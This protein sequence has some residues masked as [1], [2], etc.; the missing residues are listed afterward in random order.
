[1]RRSYQARQLTKYAEDDGQHLSAHHAWS[2]DA[3][4]IVYVRGDA[5]NRAGENPNPTSDPA[6]RGTERC[7]ASLS[8]DGGEP[9]QKSAWAARLRFHRA[10]RSALVSLRRGQNLLR[11]SLG[12]CEGAEAVGDPAAAARRPLRW[13]PDGAKLAF[14]SNRGDHA[15]IGVYEIA[16]KDL[17]WLGASV[18]QDG[19]PSWSPDGSRIAF[20]ALPSGQRPALFAPERS[21]IP[22]SVWV[23]D[24][25]SGKCKRGLA[26]RRR[27]GQRVSRGCRRRSTDVGRRRPHRFSVGTRWLASPVFDCTQ[28]AGDAVVVTPGQLRVEYAT[29]SH[30]RRELIFNSNQDDIDRRHLWR[31]AGQRRQAL[32]H[33]PPAQASNGCR[34]SRSTANPSR[35]CAPMQNIQHKR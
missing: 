13:S 3:K 28:T 32:S 4:T 27:R 31:D 2:R 12:D 16:S 1:M 29:L 9:G 14:V 6:G 8:V 10:R 34:N 26:R 21:A 18:D 15:F 24:V 30:D 35:I 19:N 11:A 7:G 5:A 25:A 23:A 33:V 17:R 20:T 22:W